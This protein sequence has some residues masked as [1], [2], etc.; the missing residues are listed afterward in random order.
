[1]CVCAA[2]CSEETAA[3]VECFRGVARKQREGVDPSRL[4]SCYEARQRL[5]IC[6]QNASSRL[7]HAAVGANKG[8]EDFL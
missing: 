7:L 3:W 5:E 8:G 1:M 2:V 4:G 6:T